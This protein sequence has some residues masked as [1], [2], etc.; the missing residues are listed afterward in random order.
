MFVD[1]VDIFVSSGHGGR[2]AV[3]FRREKF[4]LNGGPDGGDGGKGGDVKFIAKEN[5][6]TLSNFRG[7]KNYKAQNGADGGARNCTGKSGACLEIF[8][9]L[10]TLLYEYESGVLLA[11]MDT[12]GKEIVLLEGGIGGR[13]N[14]RFKSATKQRPT[15]AQ[16]G[17]PGASLHLKLELKLIADVALVGFPNVGKSTLISTVS[18]ARPEVANYEFTTLT[19]KLGVVNIGYDSFVIADIP[20]LIE[21]ASSGKGLGNA[22][23]AHIERTKFLLFIIDVANYRDTLVQLRT[24]LVELLCYGLDVRHSGIALSKVDL[25]VDGALITDFYKAIGVVPNSDDSYLCTKT[26]AFKDMGVIEPKMVHLKSALGDSAGA[27]GARDVELAV[28]FI[29]PFSSITGH[30]LDL[31][32]STLLRTLRSMGDVSS[33]GAR[34]LAR[35]DT[36]RA[37]DIL[38]R[39][40]FSQNENDE[41]GEIHST[42]AFDVESKICSTTDSDFIGDFIYEKD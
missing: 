11:D 3:S 10:G 16:T 13:G 14:A 31:L 42:G 25:D 7:K 24:L 28:S 35:L 41:N 21:D 27:L 39:E 30:N 6:H 38:A 32:T 4:V 40:R 20:G 1:K 12:E 5:M 29:I 33:V 18:N 15:F 2:G 36:R 9:P 34:R 26:E 22:F 19:P 23:L 8:V 17:R 37:Q